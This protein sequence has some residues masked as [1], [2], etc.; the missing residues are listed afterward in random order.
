MKG[1][2]PSKPSSASPAVNN[3]AAAAAKKGMGGVAKG[4]V[5]MA[6]GSDQDVG[7]NEE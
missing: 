1:K 7:D 6:V 3:K 2:G 5:V 4:T